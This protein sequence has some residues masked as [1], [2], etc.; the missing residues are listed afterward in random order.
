MKPKAMLISIVISQNDYKYNILTLRTK[1]MKPK[2]HY[3]K[4]IILFVNFIPISLFAQN[5]A[6][7]QITVGKR[8]A[9]S[10][11]NATRLTII[12][13]KHTNS[14]MFNTRDTQSDA[15]LDLMYSSLHQITFKWNTGIGIGTTDPKYKLDV[16]GIIR[17]KEVLVETGWADFV[18]KEGYKLPTLSDV[19]AHIE[20]NGHLPGIPSETE[21]KENG[22]IGLSEMNTKLLQKI[23]ELTL[24][25]IQQNKEIER[26][27]S[28]I[29]DL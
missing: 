19:E 29:D 27:K 14:W 23:E 21:I 7:D 8:S 20:E 12:P 9:A 28:K 13:F 11:G 15:Y 16:N 5:E 2:F 1:I 4:M 25:V 17:A 10:S 22:G 6:Y 18:F 26:L 24:Y 3:L